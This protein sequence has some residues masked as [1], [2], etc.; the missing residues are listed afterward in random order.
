MKN[1][2]LGKIEEK[3]LK[4]FIIAVTSIMCLAFLYTSIKANYNY[5]TMNDEQVCQNYNSTLINGTCHSE[6]NRSVKEQRDIILTLGIAGIIF[7]ILISFYT[8]IILKTKF[9]GK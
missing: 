6:L 9:N 8:W 5:F 1:W 7:A 4:I 2:N 3:L